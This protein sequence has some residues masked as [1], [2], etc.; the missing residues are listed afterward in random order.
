MRH[1]PLVID[2]FCR[3]D[4]KND[5]AKNRSLSK[6]PSIVIPMWKKGRADKE[7]RGRKATLG[8]ISPF[9]DDDFYNDDNAVGKLGAANT[10]REET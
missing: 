3:N 5:S 9:N 2:T 8:M 7:R 10:D 4:S 1:I 6:Q